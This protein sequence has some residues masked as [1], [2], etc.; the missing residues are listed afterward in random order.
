ML[1]D[2]DFEHLMKP[3]LR[4]EDITG[5]FYQDN[6]GNFLILKDGEG[7][8]VDQNGLRVNKL[9]YLVD[10]S[11]NIVDRGKQVVIRKQ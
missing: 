5:N 2:E 4:I 6:N 9:G 3:K 11:G 7:K 10:E 8:L 1:K